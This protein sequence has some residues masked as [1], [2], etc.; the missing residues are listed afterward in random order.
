[1]LVRA[2][3][4]N[5]GYPAA[6]YEASDLDLA[7]QKYAAA[8]LRLDFFLSNNP[9]TPDLL[10]LGWRIAQAQNDAPSAARYAQ[11]LAKEFPGSEQSRSLAAGQA[12]PG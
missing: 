10:L 1:M 6:V 3:R 8:R 11:R 7:Q 12:N 2:Q 4:A 5:P 9:A